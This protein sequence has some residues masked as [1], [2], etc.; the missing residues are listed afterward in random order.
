[1]K[2]VFIL[3]RHS[4][5]SEGLKALLAREPELE[6]VGHETDLERAVACIA[7][8][9]PDVVIVDATECTGDGS[10]ATIRILEAGLRPCVITLNLRDNTLSIYHGEHRTVREVE[11]FVKAIRT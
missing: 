3:S 7:A 4:L 9:E 5:L 10:R 2:R 6:I 1:M 11:D 8:L